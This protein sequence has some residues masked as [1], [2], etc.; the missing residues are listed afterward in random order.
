[1]IS[2]LSE[3]LHSEEFWSLAFDPADPLRTDYEKEFRRGVLEAREDDLAWARLAIYALTDVALVPIVVRLISLGTIFPGA[4]FVESLSFFISDE[5][6]LSRMQPMLN[7]TSLE[8]RRAIAT[9][10]AA[11]QGELIR[12]KD[13][14]LAQRYSRLANLL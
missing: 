12:R 7:D 8:T 9:D 5:E 13:C 1:M 10:I 11:L 4:E 2:E 14:D 6:T 3:K